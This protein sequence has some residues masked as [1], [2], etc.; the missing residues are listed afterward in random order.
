MEAAYVL[1]GVT[2]KNPK[3]F[4]NSPSV[5]LSEKEQNM[6]LER[7]INYNVE[8]TPLSR[9]LPH[10]IPPP[11]HA[12]HHF[13]MTGDAMDVHLF[14]AG[15]FLKGTQPLKEE[16][17]P[18]TPSGFS[19][20]ARSL[21]EGF[22]LGGELKAP[23]KTVRA[24][25]G[26]EGMGAS[27]R[28]SARCTAIATPAAKFVRSTTN[29]RCGTPATR[30]ARIPQLA[31]C[32]ILYAGRK[33]CAEQSIEMLLPKPN[34]SSRKYRRNT[35]RSSTKKVENRRQNA[36]HRRVPGPRANGELPAAVAE[37]RAQSRRP[38][39]SS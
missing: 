28:Q 39:C 21:G 4:L 32:R 24:G 5:K 6:I 22:F 7:P 36:S 20:R 23:R 27:A 11:L 14:K 34:T 37:R 30:C 8:I 17:K 35:L 15:E 10:P 25:G 9:A 13:R 1:H 33:V 16:A 19:P 3:L 29:I 31:R 26:T 12:A 38:R 2:M 18:P